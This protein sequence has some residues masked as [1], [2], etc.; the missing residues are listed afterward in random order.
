MKLN[1]SGE[2]VHGPFYTRRG[3]HRKDN[4]QF[5]RES[6]GRASYLGLHRLPCCGPQP[7]KE[8]WPH[9]SVPTSSVCKELDLFQG[10]KLLF[11]TAGHT[12]NGGT[13]PHILDFQVAGIHKKHVSRRQM[14]QEK[15]VVEHFLSLSLIVGLKNIH[16]LSNVGIIKANFHHQILPH[17]LTCIMPTSVHLW[18]CTAWQPYSNVNKTSLFQIQ[19]FLGCWLTL[20]SSPNKSLRKGKDWL[21][22]PWFAR[23]GQCMNY[24]WSP[25]KAYLHPRVFNY[26]SEN[27]WT[28]GSEKW[29]GGD[30]GCELKAYPSPCLPVWDRKLMR[31]FLL[32]PL[33]TRTKLVVDINRVTCWLAVAA[34]RP[35]PYT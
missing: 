8:E 30:Q 11:R 5:C 6:Q 26:T 2:N 20:G 32:Q 35:M 1:S 13:E 23:W 7:Q 15:N 16:T 19:H 10:I 3:T 24:S 31:P 34:L 28:Q 33:G 18:S 21:N 9:P 14:K 27:S 25:Q 17:N 29:R 12:E 22:C 4:F